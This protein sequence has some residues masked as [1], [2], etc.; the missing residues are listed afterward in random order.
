MAEVRKTYSTGELTIVWQ[1]ALCIH[2]EKCRHGLPGVFDPTRR[3]WIDAGAASAEEIIAQV[4]RCPSG[5]L[6]IDQAALAVA[7]TKVAAPTRIEVLR[8][9]PLL[10]K[11]ELSVVT[12]EGTVVTRSGATAF[13]R[14]GASKNKPFCDGSHTSAGFRG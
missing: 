10:V 3:P 13:C 11:G 7:D 6:S 1:P 5:A 2:S 4:G 8:D 9:G 14:C 12:A